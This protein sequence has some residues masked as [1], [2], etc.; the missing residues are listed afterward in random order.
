MEVRRPLESGAMTSSAAA[1][2]IARREMERMELVYDFGG[3]IGGSGDSPSGDVRRLE[4]P[5]GSRG[6][7]D[8]G[9]ERSSASAAEPDEELA[10]T[11]CP[12]RSPQPFEQRHER[13]SIGADSVAFDR[14]IGN[15]SAKTLVAVRDSVERAECL[16]QHAQLSPQPPGTRQQQES[17]VAPTT[18]I[19][20]RES[21]AFA[22]PSKSAAANNA[23]AP[24]IA[25]MTRPL[26][27][28]WSIRCGV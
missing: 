23:T 16:R 18:A 13:T 20:A 7:E 4:R 1:R 2:E 22:R 21:E 19:S 25:L 26:R 9:R 8:F 28:T 17:T 5:K 10:A 11:P 24:T 27:R 12:S 3:G 6:F 15:A 14:A